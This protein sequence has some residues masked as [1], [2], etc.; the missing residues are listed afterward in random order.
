MRKRAASG[1]LIRGAVFVALKGLKGA[2]VRSRAAR[3]L[4]PDAATAYPQQ[5]YRTSTGT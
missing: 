3:L 4:A 5:P 2:L 1:Y